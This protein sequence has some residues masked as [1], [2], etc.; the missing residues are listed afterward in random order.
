MICTKCGKKF[1]DSI[2]VCPNC[3]TY[4]GRPS[5]PGAISNGNAV[6]EKIKN[7]PKKTAIAVAIAVGVPLL[8]L[9]L[10]LAIMKT[11][12]PKTKLTSA[13]MKEPANPFTGT[14][15]YNTGEALFNMELFFEFKEDKT[16]TVDVSLMSASG[17]YSYEG[18]AIDGKLTLNIESVGDYGKG[19]YT[20]HVSEN[21]ISLSDTE[22][23][24]VLTRVEQI[25]NEESKE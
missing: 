22:S 9:I 20:Y 6:L 4:C 8:V 14:W 10:V 5:S 25:V 23:T 11:S 19:T 2:S 13:Q 17:T 12:E 16:V 15:K 21:G 7:D 18:D 3:G 1:D 24:I